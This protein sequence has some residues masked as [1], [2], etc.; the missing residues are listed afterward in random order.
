MVFNVPKHHPEIDAW[1]LDANRI[2]VYRVA[3]IYLR[4]SNRFPKASSAIPT[5]EHTSP[6][7]V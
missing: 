4:G 1:E 7:F 5:D 2:L 6:F 3:D